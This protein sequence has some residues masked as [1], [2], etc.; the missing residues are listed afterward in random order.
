MP[1]E[2]LPPEPV[3]I[4]ALIPITRPA[5][6]SRGPPEL[7]GLIEASVWMTLEIWKPLGASIW[8]CL[9]E[10][11]PVVTVR[12][13]PKGLPMAI[14]GSPTLTSSESPSGSGWRSSTSE[15]SIFSTARSVEGSRPRTFASICSPFSSK[16]TVTL[17]APSTTWAL[18]RTVPWRSTTNPEPVAAPGPP[19]PKGESLPRSTPRASMNTTPRPSSR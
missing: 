17:S 13:R 6:S 15:G 14:A 12:E 16:R 1:T 9:A 10:T 11:M 19:S 5:A 18:V 8:R 4:C 2:P 7:P 3:A